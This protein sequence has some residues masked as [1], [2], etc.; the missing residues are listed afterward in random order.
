MKLDKYLSKD[1]SVNHVG[2]TDVF[3]FASTEAWIHV[4]YMCKRVI[5]GRLIDPFY[6]LY[7]EGK[8]LNGL[9]VSLEESQ[10]RCG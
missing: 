2:N 10:S 9:S 3:N 7:S 6:A 8:S 4:D 1:K 5:L